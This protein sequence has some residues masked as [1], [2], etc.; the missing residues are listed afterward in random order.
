MKKTCLSLLLAANVTFVSCMEKEWHNTVPVYVTNSNIVT[1]QHSY[2]TNSPYTWQPPVCQANEPG[3]EFYN[4]IANMTYHN[5]QPAMD[6]VQLTPVYK[7]AKTTIVQQEQKPLLQTNSLKPDETIMEALYDK[8]RE[9]IIDECGTHKYGQKCQN[10]RLVTLIKN[11]NNA[12]NNCINEDCMGQYAYKQAKEYYIHNSIRVLPINITPLI[13]IIF[14]LL[15]QYNEVVQATGET[16][17]P[18]NSPKKPCLKEILNASTL[19]EKTVY[20]IHATNTSNIVAQYPAFF[21]LIY[22]V[23]NAAQELSIYPIKIFTT[24]VYKDN[25]MLLKG[26]SDGSYK[27]FKSEFYD[28]A[29]RL[30]ISHPDETERLYELLQMIDR[31]KEIGDIHNE[32][33]LATHMANFSSKVFWQRILDSYSYHM[34]DNI[35]KRIV[36]FC[37]LIKDYNHKRGFK[38]TPT[39]NQHHVYRIKHTLNITLPEYLT[40]KDLLDGNSYAFVEI[41]DL[42]NATDELV[43][44]S[45]DEV[46]SYF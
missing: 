35:S 3:W 11:I 32:D 2:K 43:K 30:L 26:Y 18:F 10:Q 20:A 1:T 8:A 6:E 9:I 13:P 33:N 19:N 34:P 23:R 27:D 46:A 37:R 25:N 15:K 24:Y 44:L 29:Y 5:N 17:P 4:D 41:G 14:I 22:N 31:A 40:N 28:K 39:L 7:S 21:Q 45:A 38:I 16:I 36:L 12:K 42:K